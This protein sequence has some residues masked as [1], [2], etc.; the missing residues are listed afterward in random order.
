M[1]NR[2]L[3]RPIQQTRLI[4]SIAGALSLWSAGTT[5]A[6]VA[7][8]SPV[9]PTASPTATPA[10]A[11]Q[12]ETVDR[13]VVTAEKREQNIREVPASITA[14]NDVQLDNL[15]ADDLT[16][17]AAYVPGLQVDSD[18]APGRV[19]IALRGITTL[20]SGSTVGT[21]IDETPVGSS[22]LY[23]AASTFQLDLLPYDIRRVE[24]LRGPQGTLYGANSIGGLIKYVTMEPSLTERE[25]HLGGGLSGTEN[26]DDPGWDVH[27]VA[28]IPIVQ[29]RLAVRASYSRNELAGFIDNVANGQ[30]GI[31]D[32]TQQTG[33]FSLLWKPS[34][35]I[36]VRLDA[37]GQRI[38]SDNYAVVALDPVTERPLYGDLKNRVDVNEPF[39]KDIGLISLTVD[40]DFKWATLTSATSYSD[41]DTK[42]RQDTTLS[43]GQFPLLIGA[44]PAG[45]S[46]FD[47][48][49]TLQKFTQELRLTSGSEGPFLWQLGGFYTHEDANQTQF[50]T[51]DQLDGTPYPGLGLLA[52]IALPSTYEEEAVFAN[53]SYKFTHWFSLGAGLRYSHNDQTF[54][55]DF[56][57]GAVIPLGKT[58]GSSSEDI[59][60]FMVT[61]QFQLWKDGL[62]YGRIASGYQPGGPNVALPGVPPAVAS[63]TLLS[64]EAGLKS[65]YL[66]HRIIFDITGYHLDWTDIQV[67]AV[68][69]N[70]G[71]LANGGQATSNGVE[72][73]LGVRPI[74]GLELG[75]NGSYTD[76]TFDTDVPALSATAGQRLPNIPQWQGSI[77]ADYYF[78]LWGAHSQPIQP[79]AADGKDAKTVV[80][81]AGTTQSAGWTGHV[82]AGL[83][84]VG[85][86][87]STPTAG[88]DFPLD[89]Y[90]ALDLNADISNDHWTVRVFA[91]N[92]TDNRAY[93]SLGAFT[94]L[95]GTIDHLTGVPIQ[96][97]TIG[98]EVDFKF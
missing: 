6:Q 22:G 76:A 39:K 34:D 85:D 64:Y 98:V 84:L 54:S 52:D 81:V 19:S 2:A 88:Q 5:I 72:L 93:Q 11:A 71:V 78:P 44:G 45:I 40:W 30:K 13:I 51:L 10:P 55:Q 25:F 95:V 9:Q 50:L 89:S 68:V 32:A 62:L 74:T 35:E 69:N 42:A 23:A 96:P 66:D 20:S 86:R 97:R 14:F 37:F 91:K 70:I 75:L 43:Y 41:T 73:S 77:T 17:Y 94:T 27:A 58:P 57:A 60:N 87:R 82:G 67:P 24:I 15:H 80:A 16:D 21:Y 65:D 12:S 48:G 31:N 90:A 56:N 29:D 8:S 3:F 63:S 46:A 49:L 47:A 28:N 26:A 7:T 53:A 38:E 83:R 61:P 59:V 92:V 18:G 4:I 36:T 79:V 1:N 33:H